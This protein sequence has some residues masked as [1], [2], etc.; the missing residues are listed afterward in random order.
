MSLSLLY[1]EQEGQ[2]GAVAVSRGW[3]I[4]DVYP[5]NMRVTIYHELS[6]HIILYVLQ[7]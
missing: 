2:D 5:S 6:T 1:L 4:I 7:Q 3:L